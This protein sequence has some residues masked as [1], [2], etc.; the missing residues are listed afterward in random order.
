MSS[1]VLS[2]FFDRLLAKREQLEHGTISDLFSQD[3]KRFENFSVSAGDILFDYSKNRID[4]DGISLLCELARSANVEAA[5]DAMFNGEKINTT[6]NRAVL[7]TALRAD[8]AS[9]ILVDG[10]EVVSQVQT[11]LNRMGEFSD[12]VRNGDYQVTGGKV[13]DV[14]NIGIGGSDLGP[15][16]VVQALSPFH[17]GPRVHYIA[18]VDGADLSDTLSGLDP[19]TTQAE[20]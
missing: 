11:V 17:D 2:A 1:S 16:M 4:G 3:E 19:R 5:R 8:A 6:E 13:T 9:K 12:A 15:R 7:H 20:L 14:V 18:N 10:E